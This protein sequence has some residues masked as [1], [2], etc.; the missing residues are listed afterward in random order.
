MNASNLNHGGA[1]ENWRTAGGRG[2]LPIEEARCQA[3]GAAVPL[4]VTQLCL[5][6][7][8]RVGRASGFF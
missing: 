3:R 1:V 8:S 7:I 4:Q 5:V 2:C 6:T